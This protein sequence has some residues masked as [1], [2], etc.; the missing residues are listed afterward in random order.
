MAKNMRGCGELVKLL[1]DYDLFIA[2]HLTKRDAI[3]K[4]E[5]SKRKLDSVLG[6]FNLGKNT[7]VETWDDYYCFYDEA[8]A[9]MV[10]FVLETAKSDQ[11]VVRLLSDGTAFC[12]CST[13][14]LG[15]LG[16]LAMQGTGGALGW[17]ST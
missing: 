1:F 12:V 8:D 7:S 6:T 16:R 4:S 13:C 14:V 10:S 17:I 9:T 15:E 11:S 3:M 5:P 2:C